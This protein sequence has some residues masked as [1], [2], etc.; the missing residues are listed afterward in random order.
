[1][2]IRW[3]LDNEFK[4]KAF[5]EH[6]GKL[7]MVG[8][9]PTFEEIPE[10]R[11]IDQNS[12]SHAWYAEIS[13]HKGDESPKEVKRE[14]K[15]RLGVPILRAED[16]D[17]RAFYDKAMKNTLTYEEKLE[18]MDFV[19]V[20]SQMSKAQLSQ[21]LEVMQQEYCKQGIFLEFPEDSGWQSYPEFQAG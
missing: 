11:S 21:Y 6:V 20:T 12:I 9:K 1:M 17:F 4:V 2:A 3:V 18:A 5:M 10:K 7:R 16:D 8:K 15:L 14:C 13:K 19:P